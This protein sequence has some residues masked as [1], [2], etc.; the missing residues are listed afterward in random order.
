M[1][2]APEVPPEPGIALELRPVGQLVG[3]HP[4]AE[5]PGDEAET[6][7]RDDDIRADEPHVLGVDRVDLVLPEHPLGDEAQH[8]AELRPE[9]RP[10]GPAGEPTGHA[11]GN[12]GIDLVQQRRQ[13]GDDGRDVGLR[14]F[15]SRHDPGPCRGGGAEPGF[16]DD[17]G[18]SLG[19]QL[20]EVARQVLEQVGPL[21]RVDGDA[22]RNPQ[23]YPGVDEASSVRVLACGH[24][25]QLLSANFLAV[26]T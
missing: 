8:A 14:P 17:Q 3:G 12:P 19:D 25:T 26:L 21:H 10:I 16:L 13:Q 15:G 5:V 18:F 2:E 1:D 7:L 23:R 24:G 22:A 11:L 9:G 20:C 6:P 4:E